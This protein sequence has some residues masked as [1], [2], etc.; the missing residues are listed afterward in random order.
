M[1]PYLENLNTQNNYLFQDDNCPI[2]RANSVKE[3]I[4]EKNVSCLPWPA[5]SPDLNPIEHLWDELERRVR[6]RNPLPT[7]EAELFK[8]LQEEWFKIDNSVYCSLVLSMP[9][10]VEA[11]KNSKGNSTKY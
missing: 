4:V 9:R 8:F 6:R 3:W 2:H 1:L 11:V 7:S 5:Q 10:H